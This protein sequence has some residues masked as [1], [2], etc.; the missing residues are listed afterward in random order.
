[1][2]LEEAVAAPPGEHTDN[3]CLLKQRFMDGGLTGSTYTEPLFKV[4][5][6]ISH[7]SNWEERGREVQK[8]GGKRES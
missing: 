1:M 3:T 7:L 6:S 2:G 4:Q 5:P 8:R